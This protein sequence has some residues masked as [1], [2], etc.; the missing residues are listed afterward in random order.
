MCFGSHQSLAQPF[1]GAAASEAL[2]FSAG[3]C[4]GAIPTSE[5]AQKERFFDFNSHFLI[6]SNW[7]KSGAPFQLLQCKT[8]LESRSM[9][10]LS[11]CRGIWTLSRLDWLAFCSLELE[12]GESCISHSSTAHPSVPDRAQ[13]SGRLQVHFFL[14]RLSLASADNFL[15]F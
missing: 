10:R 14:V 9:S 8:T 3:D 2:L 4:T 6:L 13:P 1:A 7:R 15:I 5:W 11:T 12:Q